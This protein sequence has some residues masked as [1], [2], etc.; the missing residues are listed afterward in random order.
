[1]V[2]QFLIPNIVSLQ[3]LGF[4]VT[5]ICNFDFG[6][7]CSNEKIQELKEKLKLMNVK[8]INIAFSRTPISSNI[9]NIYRK[10]KKIIKSDNYDLIHCHA[11]ISG[12]LTRLTCRKLRKKGLKV[13]YTAH[14]FHFYKGAPLMNWLLYY[15][16]EKICSYFIDVLITINKED[17]AL[18]Q[19]KMKAKKIEYIPGVW[20]NLT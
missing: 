18:T 16:V 9:L 1:M 15:P 2:Y 7:T 14:G 6:S 8:D 3:K 12:L 17:Y 11:P 19:K 4:E 20:I 13:I 10:L 5:V